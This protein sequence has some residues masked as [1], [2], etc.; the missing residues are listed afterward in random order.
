M[1]NTWTEKFLRFAQRNRS[2]SHRVTHKLLVFKYSYL[3]LMICKHA[4]NNNNNN[5]QQ[6]KRTWEIVDFAVPVDH[7]IKLKES[8][9]KDKYLDFAR[10]LKKRWNMKVQLYQLL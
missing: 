2:D 4:N 5:N 1:K 3:T 7:R 6:R 8:E 10:E 9:K